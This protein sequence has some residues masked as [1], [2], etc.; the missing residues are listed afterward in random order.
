MALVEVPPT[1][2]KKRDPNLDSRLGALLRAHAP[3]SGDRLGCW[4]P[5][6]AVSPLVP[7][8][9]RAGLGWEADSHSV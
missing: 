7:E 1:L 6:S 2:I 8:P 4:P 9:L 3:S 5:P